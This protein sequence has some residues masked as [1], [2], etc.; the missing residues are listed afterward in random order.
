MFISFL[1]MFW[2]TVCLSSG[3]TTVSM[4]CIPDSHPYR[5]TSTKSRIN[6]AVSSNDRHI[7]VR[8]MYRKEINILIKIVHQVGFIYKIIQGCTVN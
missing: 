1:Y 5:I 8:N 2:A 7:V 4:H 6:T 3:E